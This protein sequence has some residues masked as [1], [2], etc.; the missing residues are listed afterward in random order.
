[1]P[2]RPHP[3]KRPCAAL[4]DAGRPCRAAAMRDGAHCFLHDPAS[5]KAA[6]QARRAGGLHRRREATA[7]TIYDLDDVATLRG[8]WRVIEIAVLEYLALENSLARNRGL[9]SA[10]VAGTRLLA[11]ADIEARVTAL[12]AAARTGAPAGSNDW[13]E[14]SDLDQE[15]EDGGLQ[16]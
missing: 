13:L 4:T 1:M 2:D 12:E 10:V 15:P 14:S 3:D 8:L 11:T 16:Q 7:A 5:A 6:A 9:V